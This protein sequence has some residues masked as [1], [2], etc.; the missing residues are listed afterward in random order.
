MNQF[1]D[2]LACCK[3]GQRETSSLQRRLGVRHYALSRYDELKIEMCEI[4][5]VFRG[6]KG[7]GEISPRKHPT[8]RLFQDEA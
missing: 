3:S 5:G 4:F 8:R 2:Y 6:R 7:G 1:V